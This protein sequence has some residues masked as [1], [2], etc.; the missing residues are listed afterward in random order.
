MNNQEESPSPHVQRVRR[1]YEERNGALF[2]KTVMGDGGFDI[3]F[4]LY[5]SSDDRMLD[6]CRRSTETLSQLVTGQINFSKST[7]LLDLGSGN[8]GPAHQLVSEL[9]LT[10]SCVN[11]CEEQNRTNLDRATE[12]GIENNIEIHQRSFE[13]LPAGWTS[14]YDIVWSQESLCHAAGKQQVLAECHRVLRDGGV[15]AFSDIMLSDSADLER[16]QSFT[17]RNAVVRL[18]SPRHYERWLAA[19]RF[20]ILHQV[21]WS[22][23]LATNFDR[24]VRQ[25]CTHR[26]ELV[27]EGVQPEYLDTFARSLE[28]RIQRAHDGVFCWGGFVCGK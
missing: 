8:G 22:A 20:E 24:M 15:F 18:A 23:H 6:A 1:Q 17:D 21:D 2:Y 27:R 5:E 7:R 28:E 13:T 19:A 4:G 14:A 25:I 9:G 12:L 16:A 11:L 26:Q 10:V 3:H